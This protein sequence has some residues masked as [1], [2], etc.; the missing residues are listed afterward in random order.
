MSSSLLSPAY[1]LDIGSQGWTQQLL[2]LD[3]Q[4]LAAPLLDGVVARLPAGAPMDAALGDPV[5]L[6]LDGGEGS[7]DVFTGVVSSIRRDGRTTTVSAIDAG[8][9]LAALRPAATFE[10]ATAGTVIG[11]LCADAGVGAGEI[12]DGPTLAFYV[13][14]PGR[15]GLEHVARLAS[16]AGALAA[17]N[18]AG[19]LDVTVVV[20]ADPD[21]ALRYGREVLA[22]D[23]TELAAPVESF[24]VAGEAGAGD[25]AQPESLRPTHDFFGGSR[26]DGPSKTAVWSWEPAL[27]TP[28]AARAA[29][30]ALTRTYASGRS[31]AT[32]CAWLAPA[33]RPGTVLEIQDV[34]DGLPGGPFWID[35]VSH[36]LSAHGA[37]TRARLWAAGDAFDPSALLGAIGALL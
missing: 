13:A 31:R 25:A 24:V 17:V 7:Q 30:S 34:P 3:V 19:E 1:E 36:T 28:A 5:T 26:P 21:V 37:A 29:S 12:E 9:A 33:L 35:R 11:E 6:S 8:G 20:G 4:L 16:W 15:S 27:R 2:R 18:A 23:A 14:D 10:Q 32:L 22:L